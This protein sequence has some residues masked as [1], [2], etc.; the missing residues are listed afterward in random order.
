[1]NYINFNEINLNEYHLQQPIFDDIKN[2]FIS[3][4]NKKLGIISANLRLLNILNDNIVTEFLPNNNNFYK[5]IQNLDISSKDQIIKNGE[6]WLGNS[7]NIDSI[8]N[9]FKLSICLPDKIPSLPTLSFKISEKTKI[10][11]KKKKKM[12]LCDLKK[13][14]EIEIKF[15]VEGIYF[16]T[17]KCNIVYNADEIKILSE[18]CQSFECLFQD[19]D[20]NDEDNINIESETNIVNTTFQ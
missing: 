7:F 8:Y 14:F 4:Y 2:I 9:L 16:F 15:E 20:N 3:L 5:F 12:K 1:M 19:D 18:L 6:Q 11:S 10:I 13:D 17:N